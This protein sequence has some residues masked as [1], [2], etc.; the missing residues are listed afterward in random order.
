M[1][2]VGGVGVASAE[3]E[4]WAE[5]ADHGIVGELGQLVLV[6]GG[7]GLGD[8]GVGD[9][10]RVGPV[11]GEAQRC[12]QQTCLRGPCLLLV[13]G[14]SRRWHR[15]FR[16]SRVPPDARGRCGQRRSHL[17][18]Q[19]MGIAWASHAHRMALRVHRVRALSPTLSTPSAR[20]MP[21]APRWA[22]ETLDRHVPGSCSASTASA[23]AATHTRKP[24]AAMAKELPT[25]LGSG[26]H[27][28]QGVSV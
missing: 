11:Q 26:M 8:G 14:S 6:G 5:W 7:L 28:A 12:E 16:S 13:P 2:R 1:G 20:A 22:A 27:E 4:E 3:G 10:H 21:T 24:R 19:R 25:E 23:M 18:G 9:D 17:H 15:T